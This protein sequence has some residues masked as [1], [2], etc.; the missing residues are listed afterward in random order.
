MDGSFLVGNRE[1]MNGNGAADL[2]M[3][4]YLVGLAFPGKG[5]IFGQY[6]S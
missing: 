4:H 6:Q 2:E 3:A 1:W 5:L